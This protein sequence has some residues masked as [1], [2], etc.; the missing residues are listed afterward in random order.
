MRIEKL[1]FHEL[2]ELSSE[3]A[4]SYL[5]D[6]NE[7]VA[8]DRAQA[9]FEMLRRNREEFG[10]EHERWSKQFPAGDEWDENLRYTIACEINRRFVNYLAT[11][12]L[13]LDHT[14]TR[15]KRRY[16]PDGAPVCAFK[17]ECSKAYDEHFEYRF[18]YRLRNFS[19][20]CGIPI[21]RVDIEGDLDPETKAP[22]YALTTNFDTEALLAEGKDL[23]GPV[24]EDL[25]AQPKHLP[26]EPIVART[27]DD[28]ELIN[29]VIL[30]A[31]RPH[32]LAAAE[33]IVDVL[34]EAGPTTDTAVSTVVA[35]ADH[36]EGAELGFKAPSDRVMRLLGMA[37]YRAPM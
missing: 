9:V 15:L 18:A 34:A 32:L 14:E 5:A 30:D 29:C 21:G 28:L 35:I 1:H 19:Q 27:G 31:E 2:R 8:F 6:L 13:Y 3:E 25:R 7:L 33:R 24:A 17:A 22:T 26:I 10:R 23:W 20:H 12:R 36:P 37:G 16:G 4:N 11:A